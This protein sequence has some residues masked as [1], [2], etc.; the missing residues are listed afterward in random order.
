MAEEEPFGARIGRSVG[1]W[2]S[3]VA[4]VTVLTAMLF[5]FGYVSARSQY[6]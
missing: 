1:S 6:A 5:Y 4:P 2:G 3:I